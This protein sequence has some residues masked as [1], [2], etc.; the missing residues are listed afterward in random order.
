MTL[1]QYLFLMSFGTGLCWLAWF[2]IILNID[3]KQAGFFGFSF[4]YLSLFISLLGTFSILGFW[5]RKKILRNDD[6]V[7]RHVKR[8]FRQGFFLSCGII[9]LLLLQQTNILTWWLI[10]M[11]V[12]IMIVLETLVFAGRRHS[13]MDYV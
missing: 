4:F 10:L 1:R 2:F 5:I 6:I 9:I 8:T 13:N 3:P 7:F 11:V 12:V